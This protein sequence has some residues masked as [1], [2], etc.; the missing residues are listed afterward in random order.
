MKVGLTCMSQTEGPKP[1]IGS[2][3]GDTTQAV[4]Y[5]V[6]RLMHGHIPKVKLW[7]R[8]GTL[9]RNCMSAL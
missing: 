1:Q 9:K 8:D 7:D 2:S 4:L 6:D 3:V 5:G